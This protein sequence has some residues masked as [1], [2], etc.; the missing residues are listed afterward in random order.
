VVVNTVGRDLYEKFFRG[1][2][3][4]QWGLDPS[5]LSSQVTARIPT[6]TN[7]DDRYFGD[8]Y[9]S[10]PLHG[11]TRMFE[12]MLD[13]DNI[14]IQLSTDYRDIKDSVPY[15]EMIYTGPI[16]EFFD[17]RFGKL[18]Y[19][20]LEFRHETHDMEVFQSAPV[21]N[22][23]NDHDYTRITEFKYLSGQQHE[24]TSIVYE[25]PRAEGDPY[26]P[27]PRPQNAELNAKYQALVNDTPGL[28]FVGRL[29]SYKYYNMDQV[30]GQ[31]LTLY[32]K[33]AQKKRG[34]AIRTPA[35]AAT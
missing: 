15:R 22:Y 26:Y 2:T 27:I 23:P 10:M 4:K 1:Y 7:R 11:F 20:S 33:I 14:E 24:K 9:Q 13:H 32:S 17:F 31:A 21:I 5:E 18:P 29:A 8:T 35:A 16:D 12:N 6:R 30:V 34:D 19:R 3:R 25:Y 28:Y